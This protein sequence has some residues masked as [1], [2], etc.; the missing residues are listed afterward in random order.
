MLEIREERISDYRETETVVREAFW[1]VYCPGCS[2]HYVLHQMRGC[3][4][5]VP[6]LNLVAVEDGAIIGHVINLKSYIEGDDGKRYEVL[7]L[8]PIAV[9]PQYQGRGVGAAL[10]AEVKRIAKGLGY[11][12]I[13]LCG[14]PAFYTKQG[15]E[16]AETYGIRNSENMFA[17]ALLVCGFYDGALDHVSGMYYEDSVYHVEPE[18]VHEF[19]KNFPPRTPVSGTP[20]QL[21]FL[22][23]VKK[24]RPFEK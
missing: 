5:M 14:N 24:C 7:S 23:M 1:N 10:I 22:E 8:G 21:E 6:Q 9:L 18:E 19:D 17:D 15:F 16:A 20:S 3:Q 4:A 13:L 12:A 11:R 2:E